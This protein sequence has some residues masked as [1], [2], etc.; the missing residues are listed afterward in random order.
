MT[1]TAE[2]S[3]ADAVEALV[4][5]EGAAVT[6]V[7]PTSDGVITAAAVRAAIEADGG[8]RTVALVSVMWANNEVGTVQP[9]AEVAAVPSDRTT[10]T[11]TSDRP[12]TRPAIRAPRRSSIAPSGPPV[13]ATTIPHPSG[14]GVTWTAADADAGRARTRAT[15]ATASAAALTLR[16]LARRGGRIATP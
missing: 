5:H 9:V 16:E 3:D 4:A 2:R 8:P 12:A 6:W 11:P 15:G 7:E 13:S 1:T 10:C 14:A